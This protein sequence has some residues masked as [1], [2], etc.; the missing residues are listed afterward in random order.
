MNTFDV[1]NQLQAVFKN[2]DLTES[3]FYIPVKEDSLI[4]KKSEIFKLTKSG[5][6]QNFISKSDS[7]TMVPNG[8]AGKLYGISKL[9]KNIPDGKHIP[10]CR[11]IVLNSG[12]NNEYTSAFVD[13][14]S[15]HLVKQLPSYVEETP[16]LL[17]IFQR[18]NEN[19]PQPM[20]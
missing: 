3:Q 14:H 19:G 11:P 8:K 12:S 7:K 6:E 15:K 10:L 17:R 9:H 1:E 5:V 16:D 13:L 20:T 18:E 4:K 2:P